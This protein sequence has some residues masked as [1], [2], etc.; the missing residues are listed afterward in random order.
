LNAIEM[1][2]SLRDARTDQRLLHEL[3]KLAKLDAPPRETLASFD[4]LVVTVSLPVELAALRWREAVTAAR[5]RPTSADFERGATNQAA[6]GLPIAFVICR[7]L[8]CVPAYRCNA[9]IHR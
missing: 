8:Q 9:Q 6:K 7:R 1:N 4:A 3:N 5:R 2:R